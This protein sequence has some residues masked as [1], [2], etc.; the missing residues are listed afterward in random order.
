MLLDLPLNIRSKPENILLIAL[1]DGSSKPDWS[2]F[3]DRH[4][5]ESCLN[6]EI[7]ICVGGTQINIVLKLNTAVFDLPAMASILNHIQFNGKFGCV[8]CCSPGTSVRIGK[9]YSRKYGPVEG[10]LSDEQYEDYTNIAVATNQTIFGIKGKSCISDFIK[11][12]S[13]VL[14]DP[15]HLL[16][17]NCTKSLILRL[18]NSSS[19]RE[20]YFLGRH[21]ESYQKVLDQILLPSV[22]SKPRKLKDLSFW[23]GRDFMY[24]LFYFSVPSF[25]KSLFYKEIGKEYAFHFFVFVYAC[26]LCYIKNAPVQSSKLMQLVEYFHNRIPTLYDNHMCTINMHLLLHLPDQ[27]ERFGSLSNCSMFSFE[28]QFFN[29]KL[30]SHGVRS[31]LHQVAEKVTLLKF[32]KTF[33]SVCDFSRKEELLQC[34]SLTPVN[35]DFVFKSKRLIIKKNTNFFSEAYDSKTVSPFY[36]IFFDGSTHYVS[37]IEFF[38]SDNN[39]IKAKCRFYKK[40]VNELFNFTSLSLPNVSSDLVQLVNDQAAFVTINNKCH[41]INNVPVTAILFPCVACNLDNCVLLM[42]CNSMAEFG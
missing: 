4:F 25:Y 11:L 17:E 24:F 21:V 2:S 27:I 31:H 10:K 19:Y 30:Y 7:P 26:K 18:I 35:E 42:P 32:C 39:I 5:Q 1:W 6:K 29:F 34:L 38:V 8:Y 14:L 20:K 12:P 15:L 23:K 28:R 3:L 9:G 36:E 41:A 22:V 13:H 37:V 33:L 40:V 16:F